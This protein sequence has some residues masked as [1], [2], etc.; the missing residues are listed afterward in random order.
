ML[1]LTRKADQKIQIGPDVTLTV[2]D[3]KGR[4]V[5]IGIE[6]PSSVRIL[7]GELS[8]AAH[9]PPTAAEP[10]RPA[11]PARPAVPA[12]PAGPAPSPHVLSDAPMAH[13][14][15]SGPQP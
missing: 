11:A 7:R 4:Y 10:A 2:L 12:R 1:V 5:R 8:E 14:P 15:V 6:A 9:G 3:V 13:A